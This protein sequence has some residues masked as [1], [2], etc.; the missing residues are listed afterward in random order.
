MKMDVGGMEGWRREERKRSDGLE[1]RSKWREG[2]RWK[3]IEGRKTDE[4]ME[5]WSVKVNKIEGWRKEGKKIM[6][7]R[8]E[9]PL[10]LLQKVS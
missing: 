7:W 1:K 5:E 2:E 9:K 6:K 4:K 3:K 10:L 8:N